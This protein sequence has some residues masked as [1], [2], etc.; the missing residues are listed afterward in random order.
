M[1]DFVNKIHG[2]EIKFSLP[3]D[4]TALQLLTY[5]SLMFQKSD[6]IPAFVLLWEC[7]RPLIQNWECKII[8]DLG[9][10][11]LGLVK[12]PKKPKAD[13]S[14]PTTISRIVE[15]V[16]SAVSAWR[17]ELDTVSKN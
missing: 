16:G 17:R 9:E 3:E 5:D 15:Y 13:L 14:N 10:D 8:P 12:L 2:V 11:F 7:A 4:P 6:D 1:A